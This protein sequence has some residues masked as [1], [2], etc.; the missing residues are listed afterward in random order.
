M[1]VYQWVTTENLGGRN[2]AKVKFHMGQILRCFRVRML[3][4]RSDLVLTF[5]DGP[6]KIRVAKEVKRL[7]SQNHLRV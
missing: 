5:M 4:G 2:K 1:G 3:T 6:I 7:L